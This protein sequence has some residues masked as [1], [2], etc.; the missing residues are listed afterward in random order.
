MPQPI[1]L[2]HEGSGIVEAVG[3]SVTKVKAGDRVILSGDSCGNCPSCQASLPSYCHEFFQ[4]NFGGG[5][6]DGTRPSL[7]AARKCTRLWGRARLRPM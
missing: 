3:G 1:V 5:R 6:R 2:G 7:S 4:R